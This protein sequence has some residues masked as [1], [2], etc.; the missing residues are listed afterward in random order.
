MIRVGLMD[1]YREDFSRT[2]DVKSPG[3]SIL[4]PFPQMI[5]CNITSFSTRSQERGTLEKP[6]PP[7]DPKGFGT[8]RDYLRENGLGEMRI[9]GKL[10]GVFFNGTFRPQLS[11]PE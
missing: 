4:L 2:F 3:A 7:S 1:A 5:N 8:L 11:I 10:M 9:V 6:P